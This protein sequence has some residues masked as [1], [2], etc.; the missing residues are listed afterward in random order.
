MHTAWVHNISPFLIEFSNG[1]GIRWYGLAYLA[2]FV[3]AYFSMD[4]M[5]KRGTILLTREQ[6]A[7]FITYAAVGTLAGGR[8]GYALF[9]APDLFVTFPQTTIFGMHMP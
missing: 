8:L 2:G 7:D 1:V 9:Y 5:A 4:L 3:I 6:V